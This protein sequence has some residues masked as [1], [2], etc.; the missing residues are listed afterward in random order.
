MAHFSYSLFLSLMHSLWQ[1]ALLLCLYLVTDLFARRNVPLWKR[2]ILFIL[3]ATQFFLTVSTFFIYYTGTA[4]YYL[5]YIDT[6]LSGFLLSQSSS[7]ESFAPWLSG[8][9]ILVLA[10]KTLQLIF[11]W[12]RF[13]IRGRAAWIKPSID[14]KLFTAVKANEFGIRRKIS[15]W[16]STTINTPITFGFLKPVVLLPVALVNNLTVAETETLII[17][18][19]THIKSNDYFLNWLLIVCGNFFFFNPFIQI[20]AAKIKLEREKNCDTWVL[21]FNYPAL[22]Y[23]ETLLKTAKFKATAAPFLLA[24]AVFKNAQLIKRIRFFTEEK[25][26]QFHKKNYSSLAM[27][28]VIGIFVLSIFLVNLIQHKNTQAVDPAQSAGT[29]NTRFN[30]NINGHFSTNLLPVNKI[31]HLAAGQ[32]SFETKTDPIYIAPSLNISET[33]SQEITT[34][35]TVP[36]NIIMPAAL[37][38][39]DNTREVILKEEN[40]ATGKTVTKVY[41]MKFNNG[42]WKATLLWTIS[43][44]RPVSDSLP[45]LRD[46][47]MRFYN[48]SQ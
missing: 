17:H 31:N 29:V 16:Y 24:A 13:K 19:L 7:L 12:Q 33:Q 25:N 14:L 26:L 43:E 10:F 9:Y 41:Q 3:L 32:F 39:Q 2:N 40:S 44:T 6:S 37:E 35:E 36:E 22:N 20:I 28:P 30:E 11:S 23:A 34:D 5:E 48:Q 38:E 18:E 47:T 45:Y 46:T 15:L 21:Q 4:F 42:E 8:A 1:A 27:L